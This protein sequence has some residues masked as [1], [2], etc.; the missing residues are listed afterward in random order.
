MP[1]EGMHRFD[2]PSGWAAE[3]DEGVELGMDLVRD[4]M[5]THPDEPAP[6]R[7]RAGAGDGRD[8]SPQAPLMMW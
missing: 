8:G 7:R 4:A 2:A 3:D 1:S 5:A 6:D